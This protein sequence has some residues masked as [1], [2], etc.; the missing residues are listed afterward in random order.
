MQSQ[1]SQ[2]EEGYQHREEFGEGESSPKASQ[3]ASQEDGVGIVL[4]TALEGPHPT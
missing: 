3:K 2:E 4:S 1:P